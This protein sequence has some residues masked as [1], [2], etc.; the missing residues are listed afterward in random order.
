MRLHRD[1]TPHV[2]HSQW[3][4]RA[5]QD[6]AEVV[7]P[8]VQRK[9]SHCRITGGVEDNIKMCITEIFHGVIHTSDLL[10]GVFQ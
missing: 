6:G 4:I 7:A 1:H 8:A 9:R 3:R 2:A 5:S 10:Q